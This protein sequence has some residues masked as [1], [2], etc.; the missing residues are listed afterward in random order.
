MARRVV[1]KRYSVLSP[2]DEQ[3]ELADPNKRTR[4]FRIPWNLNRWDNHE[5]ERHKPSLEELNDFV[6]D[7]LH[8]KGRIVR[9]LDITAAGRFRMTWDLAFVTD[10]NL[11]VY[12]GDNWIKVLHHGVRCCEKHGSFIFFRGQFKDKDTFCE[13]VKGL[14]EEKAREE[15]RIEESGTDGA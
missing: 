12:F 11:L 1:T 6:G 14:I 2:A 3:R 8:K 5:V 15:E 7:I 10:D 4:P 13:Y 9:W